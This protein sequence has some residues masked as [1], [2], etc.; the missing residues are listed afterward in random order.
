MKQTYRIEAVESSASVDFARAYDALAAEFGPRGEL[1]PRDVIARWVDE[2]AQM[3]AGDG[4]VRSYHL[5]VARDERGTLAGVRDCHVVLDPTNRVVV[6]YLA[7]VLV[8]REFRRSGLSALFRTEPVARARVAIAE[9]GMN[10]GIAKLLTVAEMDFPSLDEDE[11]LIRLV[12]YG[13]DG[14]SVVAP[15]ALPYFQ[16]DFRNLKE[17]IQACPLA[18]LMVVRLAGAENGTTLPTRLA[19]AA[20]RH[21]YAVFATHVRTEHLAELSKPM[22]ASLD[23]AGES[24]PLLKLPRSITDRELIQPLTREAILPLYSRALA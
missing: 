8:L 21:L 5:L 23:A 1:E 2:D 3:W 19:R 20:V 22:L 15:S 13:K 11:S 10:P 4:L 12:A 9:S 17:G 24:V 6:V 16:P 18:M 14:F 7:H